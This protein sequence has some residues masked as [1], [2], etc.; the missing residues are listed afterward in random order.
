MFNTFFRWSYS[1]ISKKRKIKKQYIF[2][3]DGSVENY[4]KLHLKVNQF[5][6]NKIK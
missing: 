4:L 6:K 3:T 2:Y 1:Y 5:I